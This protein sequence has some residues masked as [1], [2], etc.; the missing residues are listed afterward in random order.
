MAKLDRILRKM[1]E[2]PTNVRFDEL[3]YVCKNYFG[4]PRNSG[5]SHYV[6]KMPWAG[7]PRINIQKS[8]DGKAKKYQV[9]QV[10]NAIERLKNE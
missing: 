10:L 2:S 4:N 6:F 7:D 8:Q 3:L 1:Q 5:G 9:V